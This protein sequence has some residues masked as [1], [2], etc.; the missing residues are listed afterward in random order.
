M[1]YAQITGF[2]PSVKFDAGE[3]FRENA[4]RLA[5]DGW[6]KLDS[7][8]REV[9]KAELGHGRDRMAMISQ[10]IGRS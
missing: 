10:Y 6:K 5:G 9:L 7:D 1:R 2:Q 4:E 8:A 3:D